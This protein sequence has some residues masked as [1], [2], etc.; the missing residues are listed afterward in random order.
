MT[1][2]NI[3]IPREQIEQWGGRPLT[4]DEMA[5]LQK[6]IATSSIPEAVGALI[7]T[8]LPRPDASMIAQALTAADNELDDTASSYLNLTS[9][10]NVL[11]IK[12]TPAQDGEVYESAAVHFCAVISE[13]S[14]DAMQDGPLTVLSARDGRVHL[15]LT[16]FS[17]VCDLTRYQA[18]EAAAQLITAAAIS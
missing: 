11:D 6:A 10:G 12:A 14:P 4:D 17:D 16:D 13:V 3:V 5:R 9:S 15:D 1:S 2:T 18:F 7:G 8:F